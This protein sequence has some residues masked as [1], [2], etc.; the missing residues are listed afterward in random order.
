MQT[1]RNEVA[2]PGGTGAQV[3]R[4]ANL[5]RL[6]GTSTKPTPTLCLVPRVAACRLAPQSAP[7]ITCLAGEQQPQ[8]ALRQRLAARLGAR[9]PLLRAGGND[10]VG[11]AGTAER[12]RC[13]TANQLSTDCSR[14]VTAC[15]TAH[16]AQAGG[17]ASTAPSSYSA[18][19]QL[20][21][22]VA[23]EADAL[24]GIQQRRLPQQRL[25]VMVNQVRNREGYNI[26][27]D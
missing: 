19:L 15:S 18:R 2:K 8:H 7:Q 1:C 17:G 26:S 9:Q 5:P 3:R 13:R 16:P 24:L 22:G 6:A 27:A 12:C 4:P 20:W 21:D 11:T 14:G 23:P 25:R 10:E